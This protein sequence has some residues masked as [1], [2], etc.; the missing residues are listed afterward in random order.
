[1][2]VFAVGV[3]LVVVPVAFVGLPVGVCV[4][5]GISPPVVVGCVAV[6]LGVGLFVP[7]VGCWVAV[8]VPVVSV[9]PGV[10]VRVSATVVGGAVVDSGVPVT[11]VGCWV[12]VGIVARTV[13]CPERT[14]VVPESTSIPTVSVSFFD[15]CTAL[16]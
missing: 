12:G 7:V 14:C 6:S 1:V 15:N 10:E 16:D 3:P 5:V 4:V 13:I 8:G 2:V 9:P 11:V